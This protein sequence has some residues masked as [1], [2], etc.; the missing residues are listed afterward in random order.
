[1]TCGEL[2]RSREAEEGR[3]GGMGGGT[4]KG[5]KIACWTASKR[6]KQE[7]EVDNHGSV[8]GPIRPDEVLSGRVVHTC[9]L[10]EGWIEGQGKAGKEGG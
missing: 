8:G 1:V 3:M 7:E 4:K 10:T 9:G 5:G 2:R 6:Q